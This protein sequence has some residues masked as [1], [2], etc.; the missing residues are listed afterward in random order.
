MIDFL[1]GLTCVV[2]FGMRYTVYIYS[3]EVGGDGWLLLDYC[4]VASTCT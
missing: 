4:Y 2:L 3:T 1:E